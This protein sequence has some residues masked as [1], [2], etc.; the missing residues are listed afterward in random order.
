MRPLGSLISEI[1]KRLANI[2]DER[3]VLLYVRHM[4]MKEVAKAIS[5]MPMTWDEKKALY[6]LI[7]ERENERGR[8]I[9]DSEAQRGLGQAGH[10][11]PAE[12]P[13]GRIY[14]KR[15]EGVFFL[16]WRLA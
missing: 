2:E 3:S 14:K 4:A 1:D 6:Q 5:G 11:E 10:R 9:E 16:A 8:N 12:E 7:S 13:L 15:G